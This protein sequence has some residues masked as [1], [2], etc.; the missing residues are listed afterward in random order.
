M[1]GCKIVLKGAILFSW[2]KLTKAEEKISACADRGPSF[3]DQI[4]T[5]LIIYLKTYLRKSCWVIKPA[6]VG[7]FETFRQFILQ[8]SAVQ[9]S[10]LW[11]LM[12]MA[13]TGIYFF[14]K[15]TLIAKK[16][17]LKKRPQIKYRTK[18]SHGKLVV[19]TFLN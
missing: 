16:T 12:G 7:G 4:K 3:S 13:C 9:Y 11:N 2:R 18:S 1:R 10:H 19:H 6:D 17:T 8:V 14:L 15:G 5:K